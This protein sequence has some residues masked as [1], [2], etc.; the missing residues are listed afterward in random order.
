MLGRGFVA[1][2]LLGFAVLHAM[3]RELVI[4][5]APA[6]PAEWAGKTAIALLVGALLVAGALAIVRGGRAGWIAGLALAVL[7][8]VVSLGRQAVAFATHPNLGG[9]LTMLGKALAFTGGLLATAVAARRAAM[10]VSDPGSG[11]AAP[12]FLWTARVTV[13]LFLIA[14]GVQH[15]LYAS[16][17]ATLVPAWIGG[18]MFWTYAAAVFLICG[19]VG[20][21]TPLARLAGT[22]SGLMI[23]L[24]LLV[25][26]LPR[27][28]EMPD[29]RTEVVAVFEALCFAGF[30]WVIAGELRARQPARPA[31]AAEARPNPA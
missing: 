30:A 20:L 8:V 19:G 23:F 9:D 2:A 31:A 5:R 24:W 11:S 6:W 16:F 14:S 12:A 27:A 18:A 25:L 22:L 29:S 15:F 28:I 7:V 21:V 4:A 3:Y 17:V 10:A 13:G 26:H 1:L